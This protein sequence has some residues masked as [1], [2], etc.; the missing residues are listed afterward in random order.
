M[1]AFPSSEVAIGMSTASGSAGK[2]CGR[3]GANLDERLA[4]R[5]PERT[6]EEA[7]QLGD[8]AG[9][10]MIDSLIRKGTLR[11]EG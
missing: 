5:P 11:F 4:K 1:R 2:R 7:K 10:D 8:E 3:S 9:K 6:E